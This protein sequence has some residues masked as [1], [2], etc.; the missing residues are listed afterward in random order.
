MRGDHLA[1]HL[2][3]VDNGGRLLWIADYDRAIADLDPLQERIATEV[4]DQL[5]LP[6]AAADRQRLARRETVNAEAYR[7]YTKGRYF[8]KRRTRRDLETSINYFEQAIAIDPNY[9]LAHAGLADAYNALGGSGGTSKRPRRE[10]FGAAKRAALDALA[11]DADLVE[12]H[13]SLATALDALDWNWRGAEAEYKRA[14][15]LNPRYAPAYGRYGMF[16]AF[17]RRFDEAIAVMKQAENLDPVSVSIASDFAG[18]EAAGTRPHS[19]PAPR[20]PRCSNQAV[21]ASADFT[22]T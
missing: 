1:I 10:Y 17:R 2:E 8:W 11:L 9:P 3:L 13:V 15:A 12:A 7:L 4:V 22:Y 14:L 18:G 20:L 6:L 21:Y 16:L 5:R 19:G